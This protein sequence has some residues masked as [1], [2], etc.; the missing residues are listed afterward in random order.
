MGDVETRSLV[1]ADGKT[2]RVVAHTGRPNG[3][4]LDVDGNLWVAES[5]LP[6]LLKLT[7]GGQATTISKGKPDLLF[8]WPNDLCFGPDGAIYMTDSGVQ[9][10]I[11][12]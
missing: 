1:S 5:K 3:L 12:F 7:M 8:L 4:A 2:K 11:G 9:G 6:A 10:P